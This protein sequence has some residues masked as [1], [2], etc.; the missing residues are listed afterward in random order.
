MSGC[1]L[2]SVGRYLAATGGSVEW[3]ATVP[4]AALSSGCEAEGARQADPPYLG[5]GSCTAA[6][7]T[8][9]VHTS[10]WLQVRHQPAGSG[11]RGRGDSMTVRGPTGDL[12]WTGH[13]TEAGSAALWVAEAGTLRIAGSSATDVDKLHMR[14]AALRFHA[15]EATPADASG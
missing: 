3:L 6:E 10:G 9:E 5:L 7:W 8:V 15:Y 13:N 14:I 12:L 4:D 11:E 2:C 1:S